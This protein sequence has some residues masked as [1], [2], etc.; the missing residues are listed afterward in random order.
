MSSNNI[1]HVDVGV[2]IN[3]QQQV[4]ISQRH[5]ESHQGGLWEFP[6]G[7]KELEE[8]IEAALQREFE[9]E[10]GITPTE[11]SPF[12][13]VLHHYEDKSVLLDVWLITRL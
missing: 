6:G 10:L 2:V 12:M 9:E 13:E 8:S 1:I 5:I 3:Q 4:L 11:F 7:K